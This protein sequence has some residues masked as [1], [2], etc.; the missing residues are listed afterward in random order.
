MFQPGTLALV[1]S[2]NDFTA[3]L[4]Y[5]SIGRCTVSAFSFISGV[6]VFDLIVGSSCCC[7]FF[8]FSAVVFTLLNECFEVALPLP[9]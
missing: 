8:L 3:C 5:V 9:L 1:W 2:L 4:M 6:A 7:I